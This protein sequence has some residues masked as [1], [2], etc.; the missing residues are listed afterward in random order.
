MRLTVLGSSAAYPVP[1]NPSS[2]YLVEADGTRLWLDAGTGTFAALQAL[3]RERGWDWRGLDGVILSHRHADHCLDLVPCYY[4]LRFRKDP[5][6]PGGHPRLPTFWPEGTGELLGAIIAETEAEGQDKLGRVFAPSVVGDGDSVAVG[7]LRV[8]FAA[9]DHRPPTVAVRLE[10]GGRRVVYTADTG[11]GVD[12][13]PFA[14]GA[15][16]LVAEATYQEGR[17]GAP[18]HLTAAQAGELARRAGVGRLALTHVW[19][20]FDPERSLEEARAA[21]GGVPV[22]LARAGAVFDV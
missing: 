2:G 20:T 4:A 12:L 11:P 16:L 21:A 15:D 3:S 18:V 9:T 14:E 7:G 19:P 6:P 8:A 13:A 17:V 22:K 10:E 5:P 1:G